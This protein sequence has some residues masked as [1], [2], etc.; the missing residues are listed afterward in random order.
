MAL[1]RAEKRSG[2][3]KKVV[4]LPRGKTAGSG[5][6]QNKEKISGMSK[7][8]ANRGGTTQNKENREWHYT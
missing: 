2:P 5:T 7:K 1:A 6:A 4:G 3:T 8:E